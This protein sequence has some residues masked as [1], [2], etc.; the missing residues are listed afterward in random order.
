MAI[1]ETN[2]FYTNL[3][4]QAVSLSRLLGEKSFFRRVP[5]DWQVVI[6]DVK[7]STR[8]V[9]E[10]LHEN[11]NLIATGSIVAVLNIVYRH[12]ITIPY[13]FGGDGATFLVPSF[14]LQEVLYALV[15][16]QENTAKNFDLY[17]RVGHVPVADLYAQGEDLL[18]SKLQTT[19]NFTIPVMLGKGLGLAEKIIKGEDYVLSRLEAEALLDLSGMQCRW[20]RIRPPEAYDEVV[21]LI[22]IAAEGTDQSGVFKTVI[23]IIERLYGSP[24]MRTPI[25]LKAL[26]LKPTLRNLGRE[27]RVR[28]GK[29]NFLALLK[30][31]LTTLIGPLYFK[32]RKGK[33]YLN[34][35]VEM[36]DTLV[37]DGR[38]N[39]V[40]SGTQR[41]REA[42]EA[43]LNELE[44]KGKIIYGLFVSQDSV[45]SC[46]V[47]DMN[48][49]HIHFVDGSEG[50]YTH[51]AGIMKGKMQGSKSY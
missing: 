18:L 46:Y 28:L 26:K 14:L 2:H 50:G 48:D 47:R 1:S 12:G 51:A 41:Q 23:D 44:Q 39:T 13:F 3:P 37:I 9:E 38:I 16:H 17:L 25:S 11:V 29:K 19:G 43:A 33:K 32:T 7:K 10:G 35:L 5:A 34:S 15:L 49:H 21:S 42:L 8:A 31:W 24:E 6:T 40:I 36:S 30:T 45:L 27:I 20:D 22:V 4:V